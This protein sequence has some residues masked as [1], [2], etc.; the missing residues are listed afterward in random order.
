[1]S[2][3]QEKIKT[4]FPYYYYDVIEINSIINAECPEFENI[5]TSTDKIITEI[6][7]DTA[8]DEGLSRLET[9]F[10][11]E[12]PTGA[13]IPEIRSVIKSILRGQNKLNSTT[14]KNVSL[15]YS[16]GEVDV[17][18]TNGNIVITFISILGIPSNIDEL[19]NYLSERKPAHIGITYV[20]TYTTWGEVGTITWGEVGIGTWG[21]LMTRQI[22]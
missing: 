11:I 19:K 17:S 2:T 21:E 13:T 6:Y 14:I 15:A 3:K 4:Y 1:M 18:F 12:I 7:I 5:D 22:I 20:Y 16:N 9:I 10:N 8:E